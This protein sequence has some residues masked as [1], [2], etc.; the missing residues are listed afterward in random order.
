[1]TDPDYQKDLE[2]AAA[3]IEAERR[4]VHRSMQVTYAVFALLSVA[5]AVL[6]RFYYD[7]IG[8]SAAEGGAIGRSFLV[9]ATANLLVLVVWEKI[10]QRSDQ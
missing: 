6:F 2:E 7:L 8:V 1:M 5:A 9:L 10:W 4:R 3:A